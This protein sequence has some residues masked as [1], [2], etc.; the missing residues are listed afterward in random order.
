MATSCAW[1]SLKGEQCYP[2]HFRPFQL[3]AGC[4]SSRFPS[5]EAQHPPA[6]EP[7]P[8]GACGPSQLFPEA[9]AR[10]FLEVRKE[11]AQRSQR[12]KNTF[13]SLLQVGVEKRTSER[14]CPLT[15]LQL[16]CL[17][18]ASGTEQEFVGKVGKNRV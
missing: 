16:L 8:S 10:E 18:I 13:L 9:L 3:L 7:P 14:S 12:T 15:E 1:I 6:P 2:L 11:T 17:Q 4:Q 5:R